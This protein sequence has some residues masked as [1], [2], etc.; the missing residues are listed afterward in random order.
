MLKIVID[1]NGFKIFTK[2]FGWSIRFDVTAL[3][4]VV[5]FVKMLPHE[6]Y[7]IPP[8]FKTLLAPTKSR[9]CKTPSCHRLRS[10]LGCK[11]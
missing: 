2:E 7:R 6:T 10:Y 3:V 9:P 1:A 4:V 5:P 8:R 11:P